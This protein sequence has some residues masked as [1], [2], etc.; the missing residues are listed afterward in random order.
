MS[1]K[2]LTVSIEAPLDIGNRVVPA[3]P[4]RETFFL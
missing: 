2:R 4:A 1:V 3:A